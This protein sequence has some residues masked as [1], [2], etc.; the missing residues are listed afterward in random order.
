[1]RLSLHLWLLAVVSL[2]A[3]TYSI[4]HRQGISKKKCIQLITIILTLFSGLRSWRMGDVYHYCYAFQH[5]NS[6]AWHLDLSSH[7]SIGTQIFYRMIGQMNLGFEVCLFLIAAFSAISLGVFIYRYSSSPFLSYLIYIGLG[8]YMFTL[9]ALKQTIAM[10]FIMW[11][12]MSIIDSKPKRFLFFTLLAALFH[13]PA[14]VFLPAYYIARKKI[15]ATYFVGLIVITLCI[16]IFRDQ[17]VAE[18][19]AL[20][21]EDEFNFDAA[22]GVGGKFIILLAILLFSIIVHPVRSS[23]KVYQHLFNMMVIAAILQ[24]F[25]VYDNVF[26]RLADYY[27]Q[28]FPA[29]VPLMLD[30]HLERDENG[31]KHYIGC[32][33][34]PRLRTAATLSI[35]VLSVLIY[36]D[37]LNA[38]TA[39]LSDFRFIWEV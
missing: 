2:V 21:Y 13:T 7:D 31:Q 15:D 38:S 33:L 29:F 6:E 19:S 20:Y 25:S 9:S 27:F 16:V 24:S 36:I 4:S 5:C 3:M 39:L 12:M 1:M 28:F 22:S 26:T 18:M 8:S 34:S 32:R 35:S 14:L 17:I 23:Y 37:T 11:A 10:S 30:R